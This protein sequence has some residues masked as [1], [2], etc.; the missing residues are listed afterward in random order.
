[1]EEKT[2]GKL[3]KK[4]QFWGR[5]VEGRL[6]LNSRNFFEKRI[7]EY[8]DCPV[9]LQ[10]ERV[11]SIRTLAQNSLYWGVWL[12]MIAESTGHTSDELHEFYKSMFLPKRFIK[13]GEKSVAISGSTTDLSI[14]EFSD[15]LMKIQAEVAQMG[16]E[17]PSTENL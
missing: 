10:V 2:K 1:M 8:E 14:S 5:I 13:V 6:K 17:L 3:N 11:R 15:Y 9:L 7:S 16:I 12:P 4:L